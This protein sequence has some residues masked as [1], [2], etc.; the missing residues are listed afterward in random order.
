MTTQQE[1]ESA[2]QLFENAE[3]LCSSN[4]NDPDYIGIRATLH[5]NLAFYYEQQGELEEAFE[6]LKESFR[7]YKKIQDEEGQAVCRIN[8]SHVLMQLLSIQEAI[9][10]AQNSI[11]VLENK[12]AVMSKGKVDG[13]LKKNSDFIDR[14]KLLLCAYNNLTA[15]L[16]KVSNEPNKQKELEEQ[17]SHAFRLS[18]RFL[19]EHNPLTIK[20]LQ[21]NY[22]A[23]NQ[24][25]RIKKRL[26]TQKSNS[27]SQE[28][29]YNT[30]QPDS[31]Q[32][33]WSEIKR[34]DFN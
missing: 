10:V 21:T 20:F 1:F 17:K 27:P 31:D 11:A 18:K 4:R 16:S 2:A 29:G 30:M 5:N 33:L 3:L 13:E 14:V 34:P 22:Q 26:I 7:L 8:M 9:Q 25:F 24:D 19:G 15:C 32:E 28:S 23:E 12:T 6:H